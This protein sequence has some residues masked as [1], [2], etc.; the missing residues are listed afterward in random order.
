MNF[1]LRVHQQIRKFSKS[2]NKIRY[3]QKPNRTLLITT[4]TIPFFWCLSAS[5]NYL[6]AIFYY[7]HENIC[8]NYNPNFRVAWNPLIHALLNLHNFFNWK[9]N[10]KKVKKVKILTAGQGEV[11]FKIWR[12]FQ[13]GL[14]DGSSPIS[15]L[16]GWLYLQR[17]ENQT[18]RARLRHAFP[19]IF[20]P[21]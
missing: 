14:Y 5:I 6:Q 4:V 21:I 15:P 9:N 18:N 3:M 17:S 12:F 13:A 2:K 16:W 19:R 8:W 11:A 1:A 10:Q 20:L 7:H